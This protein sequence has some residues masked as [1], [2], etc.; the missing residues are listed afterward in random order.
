MIHDVVLNHLFS[1]FGIVY[2]YLVNSTNYYL[3]SLKVL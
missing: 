3:I 2:C 1:F